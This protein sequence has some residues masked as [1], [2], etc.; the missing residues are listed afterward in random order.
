MMRIFFLL[1]D[2]DVRNLNVITLKEG[3]FGN[4]TAIPLAVFL[5]NQ[6]NSVYHIRSKVTRKRLIGLRIIL[7]SN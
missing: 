4:F 2:I 7:V 1:K 6:F 3:T 5:F